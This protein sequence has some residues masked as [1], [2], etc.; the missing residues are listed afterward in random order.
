MFNLPDV[1]NEVIRMIVDLKKNYDNLSPNDQAY[2]DALYIKTKCLRCG[3]IWI[4]RASGWPKTCAHC[5]SP[6][7]DKPRKGDD[8]NAKPYCTN[9][10]DDFLESTIGNIDH[11]P[12][13]IHTS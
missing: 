3:H 11:E 10:A 1:P 8:P 2:A 5:R 12:M 9:K 4:P 6:Y 7:W 13:D